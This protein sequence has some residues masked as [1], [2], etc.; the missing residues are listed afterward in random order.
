MLMKLT[1][2]LDFVVKKFLETSFVVENVEKFVVEN[3][4]SVH[5][6]LNCATLQKRRLTK[7]SDE[8]EFNK[9]E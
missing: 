9:V 8:I 4:K 1:P 2:D 6:S 7:K 3:V 5:K